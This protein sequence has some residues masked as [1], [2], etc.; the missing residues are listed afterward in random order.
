MRHFLRLAAL[1][2]SLQA[3]LMLR[4]APDAVAHAFVSARLGE[5]RSTLY[6][7]LDPRTDVATIIAR[8]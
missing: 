2:L 6:G 5:N 3:S 1:A 8:S 7:E 4:T